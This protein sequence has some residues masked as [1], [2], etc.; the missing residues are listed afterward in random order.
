MTTPAPFRY[1]ARGKWGAAQWGTVRRKMRPAQYQRL[2]FRYKLVCPDR[3]RKHMLLFLGISPVIGQNPTRL[4]LCHA[5]ADKRGFVHYRHGNHDGLGW[6]RRP[7]VQMPGKPFR[8]D[9]KEVEIE[10]K[11]DMM[12]GGAVPYTSLRVGDMEAPS[13]YHSRI[14]PPHFNGKQELCAAVGFDGKHAPL[15]PTAKNHEFHDLRVE[16]D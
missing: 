10:F 2:S 8:P 12:R 14:L 1:E 11:V 3:V 16:M 6:M 4:L 5:V 13:P 15:F 7:K 9:L